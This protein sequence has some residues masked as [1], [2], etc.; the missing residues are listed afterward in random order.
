MN[1]Y[2]NVFTAVDGIIFD[3]KK[4]AERY[5]ELKLLQM[6]GRIKDL[7]MQVKYELQPKFKLNGRMQREI[8]Y[9]ADFVYYDVG[10]GRQVVED[11]KGHR[12]DVYK[13]KK[14]MFEYRYGFEIKET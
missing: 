13:L 6:A 8:N 5:K 11:A 4:E 9:I 3:S 7:Q 12:T 1:K 10:K 14:K 2:R